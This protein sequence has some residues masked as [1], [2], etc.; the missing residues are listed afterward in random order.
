[1]MANERETSTFNRFVWL[2]G[3]IRIH[4]RESGQGGGDLARPQEVGS[5]KRRSPSMAEPVEGPEQVREP[6][7]PMRPF[8]ARRRRTK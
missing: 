4:S 8:G 3:E 2:P 7:K 1:M 6:E 5:G